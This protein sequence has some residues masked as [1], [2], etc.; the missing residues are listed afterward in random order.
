MYLLNH[1]TQKTVTAF[2]FI[3]FKHKALSTMCYMNQ[4]KPWKQNS[5]FEQC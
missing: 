4:V 2:C 3:E 5:L 1:V